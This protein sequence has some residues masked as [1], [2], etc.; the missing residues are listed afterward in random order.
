MRLLFFSS[1]TIH[2]NNII[3]IEPPKV[4]PSFDVDIYQVDK[5]NLNEVINGNNQ[6]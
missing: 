3:N 1:N 5:C 6:V 4:L 2:E